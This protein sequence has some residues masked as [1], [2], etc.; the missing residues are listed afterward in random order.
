MNYSNKKFLIHVSSSTSHLTPPTTPASSTPLFVITH[1]LA[2]FEPSLPSLWYKDQGGKSNWLSLPVKLLNHGGQI[3][4]NRRVYLTLTLLYATN[5]IS[6]PV[7]N[8]EILNIASPAAVAIGDPGYTIIRFRIEEVSRS[9]QNQS[10][11]L[12]ISP[13]LLK[14]P[15]GNDISSVETSPIHVMSKARGA[16]AGGRDS[17][18]VAPSSLPS[19]NGHPPPTV[20]K[21][22]GRDGNSNGGGQESKSAAAAPPATLTLLEWSN[23][24]FKELC[25]LR[26]RVDSLIQRSVLLSFTPTVPSLLH[27][28]I[29]LPR[30]GIQLPSLLLPEPHP[31]SFSVLSRYHPHHVPLPFLRVFCPHPAPL[32]STSLHLPTQTSPTR[33]VSPLAASGNRD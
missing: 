27:T 18:G 26:Q 24:A 2:L 28:Y 7:P 3:V 16:G 14:D 29:P 22:R 20:L 12:R 15:K 13:D 17:N 21:K 1:R 6:V 30:A 32:P 9:H 5:G 33:P 25:D 8:Q 31:V 23:L 10:F 11:I 19:V 4:L